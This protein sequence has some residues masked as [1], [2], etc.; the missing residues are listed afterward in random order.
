[1]FIVPVAAFV[2]N[3][4]TDIAAIWNGDSGIVHVDELPSFFR[5]KSN[6]KFAERPTQWIINGLE[7]VPRP[8]V[9]V[10]TAGDVLRGF[11]VHTHLAFSRIDGTPMMLPF[12]EILQVRLSRS[13]FSDS[14]TLL[15]LLRNGQQVSYVS[16]DGLVRLRNL[17]GNIISKHLRN[18]ASIVPGR[19]IE[20]V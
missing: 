5:S 14:D 1:L 7:K 12:S 6:P 2:R 9:M 20:S 4:D 19:P 15:I 18:I 17:H 8:D 10:T 13:G 3:G 16:I 11:F